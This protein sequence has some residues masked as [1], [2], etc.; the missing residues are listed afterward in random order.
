M[1]EDRI[2]LI[3]SAS[4]SAG[5]DTF[6]YTYPFQDCT[7]FLIT[8]NFTITLPEMFLA[9]ADQGIFVFSFIYFKKCA[10]AARKLWHFLNPA[11]GPVTA[12]SRLPS[13]TTADSGESVIVSAD[14]LTVQEKMKSAK[15]EASIIRI[16]LRFVRALER[17]SLSS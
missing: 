4:S 1:P 13:L 3:A 17:F 11:N 14:S 2:T 7:C 9:F 8:Q 15:D 12:L 5:P 6:K 10:V 16:I